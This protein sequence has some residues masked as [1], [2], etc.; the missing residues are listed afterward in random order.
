MTT[1]RLVDQVDPTLALPMGCRNAVAA[2]TAEPARVHPADRSARL[3]SDNVAPVV[4][5]S[6]ITTAVPPGGAGA[7]DMDPARL[8][9]LSAGPRPAESDTR[10]T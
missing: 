2:I 5:M 6:S 4:T 7:A 10:R 1:F 3:A 8:V 9:A